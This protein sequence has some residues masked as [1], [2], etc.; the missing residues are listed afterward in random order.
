MKLD[1][2]QNLWNSSDNQPTASQRNHL[3]AQF[4]AKLR[5]RRRMELGGLVWIFLVL[6][7]LTTFV[8]WL[9]LGTDK[10]RLEAEWMVVPL[11]LIPWA[12]AGFYLKMFL[13][14]T[15]ANHDDLTITASLTAALAANQ[16]QRRKLKA[17]GLMYVIFLPVLAI[18]IWQLHSVGKISSREL[19]SMITFFVAALAVGV[20]AVLARYRFSLVPEGLKLTTLLS[21]F[22]DNGK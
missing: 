13:R 16:R 3:L 15:P 8:G 7:A 21:Q 22:Q 5:R 18:A 19:I 6:T 10:V 11:L 9:I 1:E 4:N 20:G 2:L 12:L 14:T 17:L